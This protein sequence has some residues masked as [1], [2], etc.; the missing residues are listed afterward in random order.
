MLPT[1]AYSNSLTM[2]GFRVTQYTP[3]ST[4][5]Q[6]S[7]TVIA[8]GTPCS[9]E[10]VAVTLWPVQFDHSA[11]LRVA[12]MRYTSLVSIL[13]FVVLDWPCTKRN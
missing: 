13:T 8:K 2:L 5:Y 7:D 9:V 6:V 4:S 11:Y 12:K 10:L 1:V 3:T